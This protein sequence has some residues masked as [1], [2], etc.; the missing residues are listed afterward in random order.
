MMRSI[1]FS[2]SAALASTLFC[3]AQ[4]PA[5]KPPAT[6]A[7]KPRP[8]PTSGSR[9][10]P[11][12]NPKLKNPALANETAPDMYKAKFTTTKGDFVVSVTRATAPLGADRFYNL[13]KIGFFTDVYFFRQV[14]GFVTQFGI[15]SDPTVAAPWMVAR[16]KDDPVRESNKRGTLSFATSGPGTRTTQLFINLGDNNRLDAMGF[17]AFG[18]I[19][20]GMDVIDKLNQEYGEAPDQNA[21]QTQGGAYLAKNFPRLDKV[22]SATITEPVA[23]AP[24]P[25]AAKPVAP[26][27]KP[28]APAAKPAAAKPPAAGAGAVK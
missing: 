16:I 2:V 8:S 25:P 27:A 14:P 3:F 17:A 20:E 6:A 4:A 23:T 5:P 10:L 24:K 22:L 26:A 13:V 12:V 28:V 19:S 9:P 11:R 15:S 1:A 18:A 21:I 7:P